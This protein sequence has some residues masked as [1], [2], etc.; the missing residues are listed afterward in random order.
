VFSKLIQ[1]ITSVIDDQHNYLVK[2]LRAAAEGVQ[3]LQLNEL[4]E[5]MDS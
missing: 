5:R 2:M 4:D 1:G 3:Q